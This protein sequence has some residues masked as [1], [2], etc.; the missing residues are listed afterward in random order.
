MLTKIFSHMIWQFYSKKYRENKH[1]KEILITFWINCNYSTFFYLMNLIIF[2][3]NLGSKEI[4]RF[5][6][7]F[8]L[9]ICILFFRKISEPETSKIEFAERIKKHI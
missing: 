6:V 4:Q 3:V 8:L 7:L 2:L 1:L 5:F 9:P